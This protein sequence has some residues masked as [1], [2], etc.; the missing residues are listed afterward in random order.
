MA[1]VVTDICAWAKKLPTWEQQAFR[2][3]LAAEAFDNA[4]YSQLAD[5]LLSE[6]KAAA[7][8]DFTGFG[9][10]MAESGGDKPQLVSITDATNVNALAE[11]QSITFGPQLTV[12]FGA[13]GSGKSGYARIFGSSC[14]TR[15]DRDVL[16]NMFKAGVEAQPRT[17]SIAISMGRNERTISYRFDLPVPELAAFYVFDTT[18]V[19]SHLEKANTLTFSPAGLSALNELVRHTDKVREIASTRITAATA[20]HDFARLFAGGATVTSAQIATLN[21]ATDPAILT[22]L[23]TLSDAENARSE[24]LERE[25]AEIRLLDVPKAVRTLRG[26]VS[27]LQSLRASIEQIEMELG[28][29]RLGELAELLRERTRRQENAAR[30]CAEQFAVEGLRA[31]G[32][33]AW[34]EFLHAAKHLADAESEAGAPYPSPGVPCLLCQQALSGDAARLLHRLWEFLKGEAKRL[35]AESESQIA[36]RHTAI[37]SL[38]CE[39]ITPQSALEPVLREWSAESLPLLNHFLAAAETRRATATLAITA[40]AD[41]PMSLNPLPPSLLPVLEAVEQRVNVRIEEL[42]RN[43]PTAKLA[44]L[45]RE[46]LEF[47]HRRILSRNLTAVSDYVG[48]LRW[49]AA[50]QK[51]VKDSRHITKKYNEL[52]EERVTDRYRKIF[53]DVVEQLGRPLKARIATRGQKGATV[54]VLALDL[55]EG[56]KH[57]KASPEYVFSEGEK[58]AVVLADFFTEVTLDPSSAGII[59]DD[60]VTSLDAEWKTTIAA[61]L[62]SQSKDRQVIVFTH[63]LHFLY[64]LRAAAE[65]G[66]T[67]LRA[68]WIQRGIIDGVPGYV[69]LGNSPATEMDYKSSATAQ[70]HLKR[71]TNAAGAEEQ[72]TWLKAGFGALRTSYEVFVMTEL[73]GDVV[74][75]FD[76]RIS[77]DRLKDAILEPAIVETVIA[78]VG[79]LSRYI[80]GHSHS[81]TF[82]AV[83]P[84]AEM[85]RTEITEF[86]ALRGK[87]KALKKQRAAGP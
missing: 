63:D 84:T 27:L 46:S 68:H 87:L 79:T 6:S 8:V 52:F 83:K 33:G 37:N 64:L 25:I 69:S 47:E 31:V 60:P 26:Q 44:A 18:C 30:A 40:A 42:Q 39:A 70:E 72:E 48:K 43:D 82:A 24:Q 55:P 5:L 13:N 59:L 66:A 28:D 2:R 67:D 29:T 35:L 36:Q 58:R 73:F 41:A 1:N 11:K 53:E 61:L 4:V 12:I 56:V 65:R 19:S 57:P 9:N 76:E 45:R 78:K 23:A 74:R 10:S 20:P 62:A 7:S 54:K 80:E 71:A 75:R 3:I 32:S 77:I 49:A 86:D 81:D 21:A 50:A 14:F 34:G 15:G 38:R 17:A 85:L 51:K 16:P 22:Q